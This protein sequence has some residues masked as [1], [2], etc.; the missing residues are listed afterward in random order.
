MSFILY[1]KT[2]IF[3]PV[4]S[5]KSFILVV[6]A[7]FLL[8]GSVGVD[9]FS[10]FCEEDVVSVSYFVA[11]DEHCEDHEHEAEHEVACCDEEIEENHD[12]ELE[13][14]CCE[15]TDDDHGCCQD[16]I[17]HIQLKLDYFSKYAVHPVLIPEFTTHLFFVFEEVPTDITVA[18]YNNNSPPPDSGRD[19]LLRKQNWLI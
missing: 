17:S 2:S 3:T 11:D 14:T 19:I 10:H 13:L 12:H 9:I 15:G 5:I 8:V 1:L 6:S 7:L 4:K 16:Q 18:E